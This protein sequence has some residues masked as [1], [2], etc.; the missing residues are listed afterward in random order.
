MST[1][2]T[3][4]GR[5]NRVRARWRRVLPVLFAV[6]LLA[7]VA[8]CG[9]DAGSSH[10][11]HG[12]ATAT[13]SDSDPVPIG[14][15]PAPALPV[16]VRSFDG[17]QVTVTDASR[18]IAVD[19]YGTLAQIVYA[20]GLGPKLVGR[21]TSASFP[22]VR[23]VPNVAGGNGSLNVESVLAMRPSVFLTDTTSAAPAVR[24]QLRAA[25]VT[26]VY[27]DPER[28]MDGVVPQI[29]AVAAALGVPQQGQA[30]AQRTRD[31]IAA[32]S[33]AVP[34][35][36]PPLTI[37]F[38]YLRSTAI[39]MLA[40]PGSGAD[41]LIAALHARDA[42]A[43]AGVKEPFTAITSEAMIGAAPDVL[44]VMSDGL[45]SVGGVEGLQKVPGIAQTPAGRDRRVVDM[46]D[47]VLLSFGPNTGRVI[48]ALSAAVYGAGHA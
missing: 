12:P 39:T 23:D 8:G 31:E 35:A 29:E 38:L 13:L 17:A 43:V 21:S 33:A 48:A 16:T 28:T 22:A 32:A 10:G 9:G 47:A 14:P 6:S 18:I 3:G 20:L 40:G 5:G 25:G 44:L 4:G 15:E 36:D 42:G 2:A 7:G 37:A 46:S 11:G 19:R 30:L 45:K 24:E 27:F 34:A 41:A 26:V 1:A